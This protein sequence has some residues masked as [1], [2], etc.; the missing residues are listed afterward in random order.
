MEALLRLAALAL[1]CDLLAALRRTPDGTA[2]V[3]AAVPPGRFPSAMRLR[4]SP[5]RAVR[6]ET[7][8]PGRLLPTA[9]ALAL[10]DEVRASA[11]LPL[12]GDG[13]LL[14]VWLAPN[15]PPAD[16]EARAAHAAAALTARLDAKARDQ[17]V[18]ALAARFDAIMATV[19]QALVFVEEA[20]DGLLNPPAA[21][22]LELEP[23]WVAPEPLR[24]AMDALRR[25]GPPDLAERA[26][27]MVGEPDFQVF[28]WR[29]EL[30]ADGE[31]PP[32]SLRVASVPVRSN[33]I[34][35]RLWVFDDIGAL[36]AAQRELTA[37]NRALAEAHR[38]AAAAADRA[39]AASEAKSRFVAMMSHELRT[40]LTGI[41]GMLDLL[42]AT[43]LDA[44]QRGYAETAVRSAG[45]LLAVLNDV[46]DFAKIEAGRM[47]FE[48][49]AFDPAAL[50]RE[51]TAL[52][53][54]PA[55]KALTL[56]CSCGPGV[57]AFVTGD[58]LRLRQVL[59]N[60][61]GNAL[62]FT[63]AG[64][65]EA[66]LDAIGGRLRFAVSDTGIGI[67]AAL[68][69]RLFEAF[70]Q[71]DASTARTHGGSGLGLSICKRLVEA[72]GGEI[73]VESAPGRGSTF[74]FTLP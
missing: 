16:L 57:P 40:P 58:P 2:A 65:I 30:L 44:A 54:A 7:A 42:R 46:L 73:G 52:F 19:P 67:P 55:G 66:R 34:R 25:R 31:H 53:A 27:A 61:L 32:R 4:E 18:A 21:R 72:M 35:G 33:A 60:L 70:V 56:G 74:W 69:G 62:K 11:L 37:R 20:G 51:A 26:A 38:Q 49:L 17:A 22:L 28:D 1:G 41:M 68:Q 43:P 15:D 5:G 24:A 8:R 45:A 12:D 36:A 59:I 29:W 47:T 63:E 10:G 23:G 71:A 39:E 3:T 64:R 9:L 14:A 48:A 13:L 6:L 50:L